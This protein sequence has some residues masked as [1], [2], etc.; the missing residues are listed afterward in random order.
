MK[1]LVTLV[2]AFLLV[3][4][5]WNAIKCSPA[6]AASPDCCDSSCPPPSRIDVSQCCT[7]S[8]RGESVE[9]APRTATASQ[10]E[11]PASFSSMLA[12][13]PLL[14]SH[15]IANILAPDRSPPSAVPLSRLCSLQI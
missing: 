2:L 8:A 9:V 12:I 11:R 5:G 15:R 14:A 13:Q 3:A 1:R 10:L 7:I 6:D 4:G